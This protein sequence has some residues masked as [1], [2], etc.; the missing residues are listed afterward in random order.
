MGLILNRIIDNNCPKWSKLT[1]PKTLKVIHRRTYTD[2]ALRWWSSSYNQFSLKIEVRKC[3]KLIRLRVVLWAGFGG[4]ATNLKPTYIATTQLGLVGRLHEGWPVAQWSA[5][6][7]A[8]VKSWRPPSDV[9]AAAS[10]KLNFVNCSNTVCDVD[11]D[12]TDGYILGV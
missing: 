2:N 4:L 1:E 7:S 10:C 8:P 6:G 12:I 11:K 3:G 9:A 5:S